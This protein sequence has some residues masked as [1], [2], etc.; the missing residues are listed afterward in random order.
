[1]LSHISQQALGGA[2]PLV[3]TVTDIIAAGSDTLPGDA[4]V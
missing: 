2:S 1:M 3:C 4:S